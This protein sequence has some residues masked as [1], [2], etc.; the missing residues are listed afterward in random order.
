ML[1]SHPHRPAAR[2][3]A[4]FSQRDAWL[5][6]ACSTFPC[7]NAR[8]T[9]KTFTYDVYGNVSIETDDGDVDIVGDEKVIA[10]YYAPNTSAYIVGLSGVTQVQV[11]T[12]T[13]QQQ[14][15]NAYD[16]AAWW[17]TPPTKGAVTKRYDWLKEENRLVASTYSYDTY[18]NLLSTTDATNK[19]VTVGYDTTVRLYPISTTNG[20]SETTTT[21]WDYLCGVPATTTDPNGLVTT[22]ATDALCRPTTTTLSNGSGVVSTSIYAGLGNPS[23]QKTRVEAPGPDGSPSWSES[24]F[25]G[26]G[27]TYK[28]RSRGPSAAESIATE[29]D[30][31]ARGHVW[32]RKSPY[33]ENA[34]NTAAVTTFEY[35]RFDR[36]VKTILPRMS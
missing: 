32:G 19:S 8:R 27:R 22:F 28:T 31:D 1:G 5:T 30:F 25:D 18:G 24:F 15:V 26:F 10:H 13:I 14:V 20:A 21:T 23:A 4:S 29:V 36:P 6:T 35:D 9:K 7:A 34:P 2:P 12:G 11:P 16:Q 33:Y 3:L 17:D